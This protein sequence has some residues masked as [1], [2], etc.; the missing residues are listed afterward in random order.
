PPDAQRQ[1]QP[2]MSAVSGAGQERT[3]AASISARC[4]RDIGADTASPLLP[5]QARLLAP[6][7]A[8]GDV[9]MVRARLH[10][11]DGQLLDRA[12]EFIQQSHNSHHLVLGG[13]R[14]IATCQAEAPIAPLV[15]FTAPLVCFSAPRACFACDAACTV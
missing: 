14:S 6:P 13:S 15:C 10:L 12:L 3:A 9:G 5:Q 4:W 2:S 1:S 7:V 11:G 8:L